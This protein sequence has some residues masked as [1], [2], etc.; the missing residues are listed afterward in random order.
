MR[1]FLVLTLV[2]V[3][4]GAVSCTKRDVA[5]NPAPQSA[6]N[7]DAPSATVIIRM[8]VVDMSGNPVPNMVPVATSQP[9]AFDSPVATGDPTATDGSGTLSVPGNQYLYVRAW[10]PAK[11]MFANNYY[12]VLPGSET[13]KEV[14][15]ITMLESATLDVEVL[16]A[17]GRPISLQPIGMMMSHPLH[18]PWWPTETQTDDQGRARFS[19]LPPGKYLITIETRDHRHVD[20]PEL[21]LPPGKSESAG[22]VTVR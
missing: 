3:T 13:P 9:N 11:R 16:D 5:S 6:P 14:L 15:R 4:V 21:T 1:S 10:D 18:G 8:K 17:D 20:L 2:M 22:P 19:P 12:D 7:R